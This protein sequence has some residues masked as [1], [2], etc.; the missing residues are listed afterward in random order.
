MNIENKVY[1]KV[2]YPFRKNEIIKSGESFFKV[3]KFIKST[4]IKRM[5]TKLGFNMHIG[6]HICNKLK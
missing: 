1:I 6:Y 2:G 3:V 5:L 4:W